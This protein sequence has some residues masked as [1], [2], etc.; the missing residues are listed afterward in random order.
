MCR[1]LESEGLKTTRTSSTDATLRVMKDN[2]PGFYSFALVDVSIDKTCAI[3]DRM[4]EIDPK[5]RIVVMSGF[6]ANISA[7]TQSKSIGRAFVRPA[8]RW[9]YMQSILEASD[10]NNRKPRELDTLKM[11]AADYPL[12]IL[13]AEDNAVNT[14]VALQ[15]LKRMGYSAEHAKDG[16]EALEKCAMA[17]AKGEQFDVCI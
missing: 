6:G 5:I 12:K 2:G 8:P 1:E 3:C 17:A 13:L 10:S 15:H 14:K 4:A 9:K 11:V 16:V 7:G